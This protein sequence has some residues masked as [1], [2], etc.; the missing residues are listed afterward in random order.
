MSEQTLRWGVLGCA[1]IA[2]RSVIPGMAHSRRGELLAV[3]SRDIEKAKETARRFHVDRAYGSYEE[4]LR[5]PDVDAVYIPLPNHLHKEW[6]IRAAEAGK[7]VL[8]EKPFAMD[9]A[10]AADMVAACARA[11]VVLAEAFMYRHHPRYQQIRDLI[12][13]GAIGELRGIHATFT[14]NSANAKGNF[15]MDPAMGGGALYD[16]GVYPIT[17]ARLLLGK[18]P[19]AATVHALFSP[20]HGGVDMMAAGLLEF[21]GGTSMTFDCAM[22]AAY[23]NTLEVLGTDGRIEVPSAFICEVEAPS[24]FYLTTNDGRREVQMPAVDQ[25]ALEIDDF[26]ASVLDR[27]PQRFAPSDAVANMKVLDACLRSARTRTRVTIEG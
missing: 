18:E 15:R 23:R 13:A 8:C 7:H 24:V 27:A 19:E 25:F 12:D 21:A 14:F 11:G 9:A 6:T 16:I 10:Q 5:D 3:A 2:M 1:A 22:W 17:V 4:L 20:E 26:A